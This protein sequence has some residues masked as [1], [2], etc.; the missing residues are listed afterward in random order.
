M[1]KLIIGAIVGAILLFIWQALSNTILELHRPTQE[2]TSKQDS[3]LSFLSSQFTEN[4]FYFMPTLP[5]DAPMETH[6][7][8]MAEVAGK[9][10]AIVQYHKAMTTDMT[11]NIIRGLLV[12]IVIMLMFC[13]ILM[14]TN[15]MGF[16]KTF[17]ATIFTGLI[18]FLNA[19]YTNHIWYEFPVTPD[20]I[21]AV[22]GWGL[23]GIWFGWY[24]GKK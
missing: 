6:E 16:G 7:K 15:G 10:W 13:W 18:V 9:P 20:L 21:D 19:P 3:V 22:V 4:G 12:N 17:L 8:F 5:K 23:A 14:K 11:K 2:Y 1:K 24:F